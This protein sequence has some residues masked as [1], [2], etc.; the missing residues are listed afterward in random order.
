MI[1][2]PKWRE[3]ELPLVNVKQ[4]DEEIIEIY[5]NL[6]N[7]Q[8]FDIFDTSIAVTPDN[9]HDTSI[10]LQNYLDHLLSFNYDLIKTRN[11]INIY[12]HANYIKGVVHIH[13]NHAIVKRVLMN[14]EHFSHVEDC[15]VDRE[16]LYLGEY[17]NLRKFKFKLKTLLEYELLEVVTD[18]TIIYRSVN[19]ASGGGGG[20]DVCDIYAYQ[21]NE[22]EDDATEVVI[23]TNFQNRLDVNLNKCIKIKVFIEELLEY[24]TSLGNDPPQRSS[25]IAMITW[26]RR[27]SDTSTLRRDAEETLSRQN[28]QG[29]IAT[30]RQS[31]ANVLRRSFMKNK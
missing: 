5:K 25:S 14:P 27:N 13:A 17:G 11:N 31:A 9:I 18:K 1:V 28:S 26:R 23:L 4:L 21:I 30:S 20:G 22:Q 7:N 12:R 16:D 6:E 24:S 10:Q 2:F 3:F 29:I 8:T 15:L 19:S